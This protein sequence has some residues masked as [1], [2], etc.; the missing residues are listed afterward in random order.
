MRKPIKAS[1][2]LFSKHGTPYILCRADKV[3]CATD[4]NKP[5]KQSIV[6]TPLALFLFHILVARYRFQDFDIIATIFQLSVF[7]NCMR[8]SP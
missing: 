3:H 7:P 4:K 5:I 6:A 2:M 1:K 8:T